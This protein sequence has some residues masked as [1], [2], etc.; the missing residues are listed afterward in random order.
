IKKTGLNPENLQHQIITHCHIDHVGNSAWFKKK[1][2]MMVYAHEFEKDVIENGGP[3]T[4]ADFYGV[5]YEPVK[6]DH[7]LKGELEVVNIGDISVNFLHIP[8]HTPGGI[9]PYMDLK[10]T[11]ILFSQDTHGPLLP[12]FG[13]DRKTFVKSLKKM[14][15]L[16]ADILCEGHFGV[17]EGK[18]QVKDYI[19]SYIE[20]FSR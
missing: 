19:S 8:G 5:P 10:G 7:V 6:I 17:Y 1:Y 16:N 18:R 12:L 20:Q 11:R 15:K 4:G 3:R 13:S 9:A 2:D 14:L